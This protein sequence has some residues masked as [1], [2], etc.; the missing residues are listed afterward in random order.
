MGKKIVGVAKSTMKYE[1]PFTPKNLESLCKMR[2]S[3]DAASVSLLIV[4]V[5]YH[6][7]I[8]KYEDFAR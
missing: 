1:L 4:K 7:Q 2:T 5:S 3:E 8:E 6:Y